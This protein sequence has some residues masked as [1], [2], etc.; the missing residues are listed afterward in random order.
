V[1]RGVHLRSDTSNGLQCRGLGSG[2][3]LDTAYFAIW[4]AI[5]VRPLPS[6]HFVR[7]SLE[8]AGQKRTVDIHPRKSVGRSEPRT[9]A[10]AG[11]NGVAVPAA[12]V[13]PGSR[14]GDSMRPP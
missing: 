6:T 7:V 1:Q 3:R 2:K 10:A 14:L 8:A 11:R 9:F 13:A 4:K 5:A 12:P